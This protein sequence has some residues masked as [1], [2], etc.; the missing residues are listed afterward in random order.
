M[1]FVEND[2]LKGLTF[3]VARLFAILPRVRGEDRYRSHICPLNMKLEP[4]VG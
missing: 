3:W 1:A 4:G 2:D